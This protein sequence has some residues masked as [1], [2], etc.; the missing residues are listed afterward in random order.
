MKHNQITRTQ[1]TPK[2][3]RTVARSTRRRSSSAE[4]R[5][6][7]ILHATSDFYGTWNPSH[8]PLYLSDSSAAFLGYKVAPP[9]HHLVLESLIHPDEIDA[10]QSQLQ[11]HLSGK[12]SALDC[13]FRL[14]TQA[15][16]YRLFQ[17][18]GKVTRR[19]RRGAAA[20]IAYAVRD[21]Q[22]RKEQREEALE[23][24]ERDERLRTVIEAGRLFAFE[25]DVTTDV[26]ER[27]GR[28]AALLGFPLDHSQHTRREFID[29]I[30]P[31]DRQSYV[32]VVQSLCPERPDY[33]VVF[34]LLLHNGQVAWL[35]EA[36]RATFGPDKQL[37]KVL[38]INSDVTEVR[39]S[40]RALRDLSRRLINSQE[41]ERRRIARELHDHIGQEAALLC[42]QAQRV[43][44]GIADEENTT[45]SDVHALYRKIQLLSSDISKLSHRLHSSELSFL[46]LAVAAERLC[47]DFASQY[48]I[49]VDYQAK[50]APSLPDSAKS[51]CL[52]RVLQEALQNVAKHSHA[53]RV[54]VKLHSAENELVLDVMD[55]GTGFDSGESAAMSSGLGLLSMRERLN[56]VAGR[57]AITSTLGSGTRVTAAVTL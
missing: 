55:N 5:L 39:R 57:F 35:E 28:S 22:S 31:E 37:R 12:S 49:N 44:S 46:G 3:H 27:S 17:M 53:S 16:P 14:R 18:R 40:E 47:R 13:E 56:L 10:F 15:G 42:V 38:G 54:T 9:N 52:Y 30:H 33:R 6:K 51:L 24:Y 4:D 21:I 34:R 36:G 23:S 41:E 29:R 20:E 32:R 43:D 19:D 48:G 45:R 7:S 2:P 8:G 26:I 11:K 1:T 25:W 50:S